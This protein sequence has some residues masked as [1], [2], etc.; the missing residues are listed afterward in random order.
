MDESILK[1]LF[2]K[3]TTLLD[4]R[5]CVV[6]KL[7]KGSSSSSCGYYG[8]R[9]FDIIVPINGNEY[10]VAHELGHVS[11]GEN[12][13]TCFS[14]TLFADNE[15]DEIFQALVAAAGLFTD[16]FVDDLIFELKPV[17]IEEYIRRSPM[18]L[19]NSLFAMVGDPFFLNY[20][21]C[22]VAMFD[23]EIGRWGFT[24]KQ[25]KIEEPIKLLGEFRKEIPII[26]A[27]LFNLFSSLPTLP[28]ERNKAVNLYENTLR[29][30]AK[31][32]DY[33]QATLVYN[34]EKDQHEWI[35]G[36]VDGSQG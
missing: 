30:V 36:A 4:V 29:S 3:W 20:Y 24:D 5:S 14:S 28:L 32:L 1:E 2:V 9:I 18:I 17:L 16:I 22:T 6:P 35:K 25:S 13:D 15:N 31:I 10:I 7:D 19:D 11:L 26:Y 34:E 27:S 8:D 23:A 12:I 21:I 33:P